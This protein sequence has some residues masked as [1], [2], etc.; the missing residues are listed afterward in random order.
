M[1]PVDRV[2]WP[3]PGNPAPS[4]TSLGATRRD[5]VAVLSEAYVRACADDLREAADSI[6]DRDRFAVIGPAGRGDA[7]DRHARSGH[8]AAA[9]A[10]SEAACR[11]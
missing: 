1:A 9:H 7:I 11:P 8:S 2:G 3:E 6:G 10:S 4:L 5:L